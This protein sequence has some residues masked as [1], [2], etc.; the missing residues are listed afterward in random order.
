MPLYS[1]QAEIYVASLVDAESAI[2]NF[3][4]TS[5]PYMDFI[6]KNVKQAA[7][8]PRICTV[9]FSSKFSTRMF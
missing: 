1:S 6:E 9:R 8:M 7:S 4:A 2:V 3:R 5:G